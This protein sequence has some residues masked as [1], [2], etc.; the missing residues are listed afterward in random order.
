MSIYL[1]GYTPSPKDKYGAS[2]PQLAKVSLG[3][4]DFVPWEK[5]KDISSVIRRLKKNGYKIFAIEQNKRSIPYYKL[6]TANYKL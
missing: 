5:V 4:E 6:K 2:I 1:T 3:A